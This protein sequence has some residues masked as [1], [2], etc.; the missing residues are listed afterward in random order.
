[1]DW[2]TQRDRQMDGK[3]YWKKRKRKRK[4]AIKREGWMDLKQE[5]RIDQK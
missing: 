5:G 1:M 4:D 3:K 2:L